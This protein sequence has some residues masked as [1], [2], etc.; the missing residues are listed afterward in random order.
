MFTATANSVFQTGASKTSH[1]A[2]ALSKFS[3]KEFV[4][5]DPAKCTYFINFTYMHTTKLTQ[6]VHSEQVT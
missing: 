5:G 2:L 4:Y 1:T 3:R 6:N